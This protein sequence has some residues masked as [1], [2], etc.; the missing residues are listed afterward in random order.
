M[1]KAAP[2][3][4]KGVDFDV[5]DAAR[6]AARRAG[7]SLGEWLNDAIAEQAQARGVD[8]EDVDE[9]GRLE[10][11]TARLAT[12]SGR[13]RKLQ[14]RADALDEDEPPRRRSATRPRFDIR[15][16]SYD[17]RSRDR[18]DTRYDPE[19]IANPEAMLD[20][21]IRAYERGASQGQKTTAA[22]SQVANKLAEIEQRL[23]R[24]YTESEGRQAART[25]ARSDHAG[26]EKIARLE[27][28]LEALAKEKEAEKSER[29]LR[30]LERRLEEMAERMPPSPR[31][32]AKPDDDV[33][34]LESKLNRLLARM[35]EPA[36]DYAAP[37]HFPDDLDPHSPPL[38]RHSEY[39]FGQDAASPVQP[40][41]RQPT[42]AP[43]RLGEAIVQI[44][45]RQRELESGASAPRIGESSAPSASIRPAPSKPC[46]DPV[47]FGLRQD[48]AAL[49]RKLDDTQ[50]IW[51][52]RMA[53]PIEKPDSGLSALKL[54]VSALHRRLEETQNAIVARLDAQSAVAAQ[55]PAKTD[56]TVA[57]L[58]E[59]VA[60]LHRRIEDSH[61][62]TLARL[63]QGVRHAD[64]TAPE[65]GAL[66]QRLDGL[67][68]AVGDLAPRSAIASL[69]G[70]MR[71]LAP[72]D[73][74]LSLEGAVRDL[75]SRVNESLR[76]GSQENLLR[77][78]AE[79]AAD[80]RRVVSDMAPVH[81]IASMERAI[82]ELG[83]KI[84]QGQSST[85]DTKTVA[86]IHAQTRD[87]R[88]L[89][90][91][92]AARPAPSEVIE[93]QIA[94]L[95]D[96]LDVGDS[97]SEMEMA[98]TARADG[99]SPRMPLG[100]I[101]LL[102]K[103][104]DDLSHKIDEAV[105][106]SGASDQL[107]EL[108]RRIE[109]VHDSIATRNAVPAPVLDTSR[110]EQMMREIA[111][112]LEPP[113][114]APAA[115]II[116]TTRIEEMLKEVGARFDSAAGN[117]DSSALEEL[118]RDVTGIS[119]TIEGLARSSIDA[120]VLD[121]IRHDI[122]RLSARMESSS[123]VSDAGGQ[124]ELHDLLK[125]L[126][127]RVDRDDGGVQSN[128]AL[129]AVIAD[130]AQ[131]IEDS[132]RFAADAAETA[133]RNAAQLTV[134]EAMARFQPATQNASLPNEIA[135]LRAMQEKIDQRTYSTLTAVHETL[136]KVVDRIAV[137]EDEVGEGKPSRMLAVGDAPVFAPAAPPPAASGFSI[138]QPQTPAPAMPSSRGLGGGFADL[139]EPGFAAAVNAA[140]S[141]GAP[142]VLSP[143]SGASS[144]RG[145]NSAPEERKRWLDAA[146]RQVQSNPASAQERPSDRAVRARDASGGED[147]HADARARAQ[148]AQ[149]AWSA[150]GAPEHTPRSKLA[151]G[152]AANVAARMSGMVSPSKK[153]LVIVPV[154]SLVL[155]SLFLFSRHRLGANPSTPVVE[156]TG[157]KTPAPVETTIEPPPPLQA[158]NP[159]A[160]PVR[161]PG[162][163]LER[164]VAPES[165]K[166]ASA[167]K[168]GGT[169]PSDRSPVGSITPGAQAS[170]PILARPSGLQSAADLG[171]AA[172]QFEL[173][174]RYA[175][176]RAVA[177]D[178]VK[179]I[180]WFAKAAQQNFAPAAYR[181][182]SI[183]E[184]GTG[185][186][187]NL[188]KARDWYTKAAEAGNIRAMHNMAV[189]SAEGLNGKP[190]Y[191]AATEWFRKAAEYGVRD[192]QY[193]LAI[194][195]ARGLG[196]E[197]NMSMSWAWF[198]LA[199]AQGDTDA[200]KK[201]EDVGA[202]LDS[203][204]L[205]EAKAFVAAYRVKTADRAANSVPEPPGG[206]DGTAAAITAK[207][208]NFPAPPSPV[209]KTPQKGK[210][211]TAT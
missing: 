79:M 206:W 1:T 97:T 58:R 60:A 83:D 80:L 203:K 123:V 63:D 36:P 158:P 116:D 172:A 47:A 46:P 91:R 119:K 21:A 20:A 55:A 179:A 89:L 147:K 26:L 38:R 161:R 40:V 27:A 196:V 11:V 100:M 210:S 180:E 66:R 164:P 59:E 195:Y 32:Q 152:V 136:E 114:A 70:T 53:P 154:L 173:A 62:V 117:P 68:Q 101:E 159:A 170:M 197:Q 73:S 211:L 189:L 131:R 12:L 144:E 145:S 48:V 109:D 200:A 74:I 192:S 150:G 8:F 19:P 151:S 202:R 160:D 201:Q 110:L 176:G 14:R 52:E 165:G 183:Y 178:P 168:I 140:T 128:A 126:A 3:S 72:R 153:A 129:A 93:R 44:A 205:A 23:S 76:N 18:S 138:P 177:R 175:D 75:G 115:E 33:V 13:G 104:I 204:Q 132:R 155:L 167:G 28:R 37:D 98:A 191:T 69:E 4:I 45:R 57:A 90:Q 166:T 50:R 193:N 125:S 198:A 30:G 5:R 169:A 137:L 127:A 156:I 113:A 190:D 16:T 94:R 25:H 29:S 120:D 43:P 56:P 148:A 146:R 122:A 54:E 61:S 157:G 71:E 67:S 34:R 208:N 135:D 171:D 35:D 106:Q 186:D 82:R 87:I 194:L 130:L 17:A 88:D 9:E 49:A 187:R 41:A 96:R 111:A 7:M 99:E 24:P 134:S 124:A 181:L 10:A 141:G 163:E 84:G 133:A 139:L 6:E 207:P 86:E 188:E 103:R 105:S 112:K 182:G 77:P 15:E 31:A 185:T 174:S 85:I 95:A 51:S 143:D 78:I 121:D 149:M 184:R 39:A 199:A 108:A 118:R 42:G 209:I 22:F 92:A 102:A 107:D 142:A 81:G 162:A 2:W 65:L 64:R